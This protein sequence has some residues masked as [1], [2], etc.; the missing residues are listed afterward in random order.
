MLSFSTIQS[1]KTRLSGRWNNTNETCGVIDL[2]GDI[3]ELQNLAED[4]QNHFRFAEGDLDWAFASWHTH[5]YGSSNLSVEDYWFFKS[6][7]NMVHFII[8]RDE[9]SCYITQKGVLYS[10][11]EEDD[12]PS[13]LPEKA[14]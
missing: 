7:P 5:P 13:W 2:Q 14:P 6:L 9:V 8:Y 12:L 1:F 11:D 10:I 4:P 3:R